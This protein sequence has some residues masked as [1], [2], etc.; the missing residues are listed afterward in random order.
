MGCELGIETADFDFTELW[1]VEGRPV[2]ELF[3]VTLRVVR[4]ERGRRVA[5]SVLLGFLVLAF[6]YLG[7]RL[8]GGAA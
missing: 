5:R 8:I 3:A 1:M 6:C 7:I 2:Q 4:R